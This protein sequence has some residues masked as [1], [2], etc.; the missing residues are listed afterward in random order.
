MSRSAT[1]QLDL[2]ALAATNPILLRAG[3]F[4]QVMPGRGLAVP[5]GLIHLALFPS[6]LLSLTTLCF[7]VEP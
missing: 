4:I 5:Y 3:V 2:R 1:K 6:E 7:R